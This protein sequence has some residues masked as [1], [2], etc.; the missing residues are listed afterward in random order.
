MGSPAVPAERLSASESLL[1]L[2]T[3]M[4]YNG[5]ESFDAMIGIEIGGSNGLQPLT[6][7]SSQNF[8]VPTVDADWMGTHK[9]V[10]IQYYQAVKVLTTSC[11]RPGISKLVAGHR[12]SPRRRPNLAVLHCLWRRACTYYG[13]IPKRSTRRQHTSSAGYRHGLL[14]WFLRQTIYR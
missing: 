11:K 3:M 13:K 8:N 9:P 6:I 12:S 1:A 7:G 4:E 14:R 2:E 10:T 5:H